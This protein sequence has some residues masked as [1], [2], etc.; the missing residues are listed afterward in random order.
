MWFIRAAGRCFPDPATTATTAPVPRAWRDGGSRRPNRSDACP[1]ARS[2]CTGRRSLSSERFAISIA[3]VRLRHRCAAPNCNAI[4][5]RAPRILACQHRVAHDIGDVGGVAQSHVQTLRTD[6]RHAHARLRRPAR[7]ASW[8]I[9]GAVQC[10]RKH[11]VRLNRDAAENGMRLPSRGLR[12]FIIVNAISRSASLGAVT[13]TTLLR[14]PGRGTNTH[15]PCG[16]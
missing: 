3:K 7:C 8:R 5:L 14:S 9:A 13:H 16:V 1:T 6:R 4:T 2:V 10:E 11:A 12:Q 15:G